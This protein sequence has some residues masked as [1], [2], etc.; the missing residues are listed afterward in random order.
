[1]MFAQKPTYPSQLNFLKKNPKEGKKIVL[2]DIIQYIAKNA[3]FIG[4]SQLLEIDEKDHHEINASKIK[5][6]LIAD[7]QTKL[8][9]LPK[10]LHQIF[11]SFDIVRTG[12]LKSVNVPKN[13][14]VSFFSS[15]FEI[16]FADKTTD[17]DK[18]LM[19][20]DFIKKVYQ[21]GKTKFQDFKY[22][23]LGWVQKEF[24]DH[25][26]KC[27]MEKD[28]FRYSADYLH[29]NIFILDLESDTLYY[30]GSH[31]YIIHKLNVFLLR[32][33]NDQFEPLYFKDIQTYTPSHKHHVVQNLINNPYLVEYMDNDLNKETPSDK[34]EIGSE[35]LRIYIPA[36]SEICDQK[37]NVPIIN[38]LSNDSDDNDFEEVFSG[39]HSFDKTK[40]IENSPCSETEI[41]PAPTDLSHMNL[42]ELK[43][44]AKQN[45]IRLTYK[46]KN[47]GNSAK[48]KKMLIDELNN[49]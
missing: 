48:T 18:Q 15:L 47:G 34:F 38:S 2:H 36:K 22:K 11:N 13:T 31:K 1:M 27:S 10:N 41:E 17:N 9:D 46:N 33:Q 39:D 12:M 37:K 45:G 6:P 4:K 14:N 42:S 19:I 24:M 49:K 23:E 21:D 3:N 28:I 30:S 25:L 40:S 20:G 8:E 35:D 26:K 43:K 32:F 44:M 7:K 5:S 16:F 29:I